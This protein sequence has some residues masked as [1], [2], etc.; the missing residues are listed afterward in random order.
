[1][2]H[3]PFEGRQDGGGDPRRHDAGGVGPWR[4]AG[5]V[6]RAPADRTPNPGG[7]GGGGTSLAFADSALQS[8][9]EQAAAG[10]G[11]AAGLVSLTAKERGIADLG[12][13]EQLTR[14]EV[15]DLYGNEIRDLS[16]LAEL[17]RLRYLDLGAKATGSREVS[18][19]ASLKGLR[20]LLLADNGV[21]DLSD[22]AGLD[23]LQS[24]DLTGNPLS[25]A[26]RAQLAALG[27]RGV[28][29]EFT[30]PEPEDSVEVVPPEGPGPP[31]G[32]SQLLFSSN[33][34]LKGSYL[35]R[36]EV[37]SLDLETGEV[38]NL[39]SVLA[40]VPRSDGS[41]PDSL[42][43][44]YQTRNGE[45]PARVAGRNEGSLR[46]LPGRQQ[47]DLCHGR[48]RRPSGEPHPPRRVRLGSRLVARRPAH[49]LR[50]ETGRDGPHLRHERR[51]Q[52]RGA[53]HLR[54]PRPRGPSRRRGPPTARPSPASP[55]RRRPGGSIS[56]TRTAESSRRC[57]KASAG[58]ILRGRPTEPGSPTPCRTLP[59]SLATSL[60]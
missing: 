55:V 31:L 40:A 34:R 49:R 52:R 35:S 13:I 42:E 17:R 10:T 44:H 59:T 33:R 39:C 19:L 53:A 36:R 54:A 16:P 32:N 14:L 60:S 38:V 28:T 2:V 46:F 58:V 27:E 5:R 43:Q 24:L 50:V 57:R 51:R 22:L 56:W 6:R 8:A 9:V 11:D 37:H 26:A 45:E 18:A 15:L 21:T 7:T 29:V 25:E 20:V 41:E 23:S 48:R 47:G 1:M 4:P 30:A 12:G 3:G